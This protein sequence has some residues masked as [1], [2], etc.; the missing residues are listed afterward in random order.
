[1]YGFGFELE[2]EFSWGL[3]EEVKRFDTEGTEKK[4]EK[5]LRKIEACLPQRR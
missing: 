1:L 3:L 2:R 4:A 5:N